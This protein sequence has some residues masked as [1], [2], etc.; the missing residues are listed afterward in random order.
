MACLLQA[1]RG[2]ARTLLTASS[3][4]RRTS[5]WPGCK[6]WIRTEVVPATRV[7]MS[8]AAASSGSNLFHSS[9]DCS[10]VIKRER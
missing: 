4:S 8:P 2:S 1:H 7:A 3:I 6:P 5:T 9:G 10:R